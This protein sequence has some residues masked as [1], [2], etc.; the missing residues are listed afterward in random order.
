MAIFD[1]NP[2]SAL[3]NPVTSG[4][5]NLFEGMNVFGA[6]P[7]EA[8]TGILTKDQ[9]DK[10]RNQSILQGLLGA[11]A[12]Y[13]AT[14][15]NLNAGSALPYLGKAF[16]GGM[17][18]S[19]NVYDQALAGKVKQLELEQ[20]AKKLEME[21]L[22]PTSKLIKEKEARFAKNPND[23]AIALIDAELAQS[24]A[25][26]KPE[27]QRLQ[28]FRAK[29]DSNSPTYKQQ[30]EEVNKA[31][32]KA[33][34]FAPPTSVV[35][36]PGQERAE[37]KAVGE[38]FGKTYADIQSAGASAT[39]KINKVERL[40][41]LLDGVQTGKLTPL[42]VDVASTAASL[43]FKIDPKL[44]NKQAADALSKDMAL[45]LRNPS[46]GAGMPGALSN[47]DREFLMSM[48]PSLTSDPESR[49]LISESM[50]KLAKRDQ[51]VAKIA[52]EYRKKNGNLDEGFYDELAK[53]S[54]TN[55]LFTKT[56]KTIEVKY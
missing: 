47:S 1:N 12:T 41:T 4:I 54:E 44:G 7:S 11:G 51:E 32:K 18:S 24:T 48:T 26:V 8:L 15:K 20:G 56:N 10:L 29:L 13:L 9:Q 19:Q 52:R 46:G 53:F 49:K 6:R 5:G 33:T 16:L 42:G 27:I 2:L 55:P 23:P 35:N 45:E 36:L 14:P 3:T 34:E 50:V 17:Q 37:S 39:N 43:G 22:S 30:L 28:E 31:I 38:F 40:N 21:G 25:L